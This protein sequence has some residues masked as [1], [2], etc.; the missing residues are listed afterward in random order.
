MDSLFTLL[1][2]TLLGGIVYICS[3]LMT[4]VNRKIQFLA[5]IIPMVSISILYSVMAQ[6]T[7]LLP[8]VI[9]MTTLLS[10]L[11]IWTVNRKISTG[12]VTD[13]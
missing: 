4:R 7:N 3:S 6:L 10:L 1:S 2:I 13:I 12:K 8:I 5:V 11:G 9:T